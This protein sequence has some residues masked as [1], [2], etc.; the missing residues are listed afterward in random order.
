MKEYAIRKCRRCGTE[1]KKGIRKRGSQERYQ[2]G[3]LVVEKCPGCLCYA[4]MDIIRT[5]EESK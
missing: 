5:V 1:S 4:E 2:C 3:E